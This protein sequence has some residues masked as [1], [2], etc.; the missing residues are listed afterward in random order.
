MRR[1]R[2]PWGLYAYA[3]AVY[4]F[5]FAPI[6]VVVVNSFNSDR[7][8]VDWGGFTLHWY[9]D[10]W[11]N[12]TIL[13]AAWTSLMIAAI[14]AGV[15]TMLGTSAALALRRSRRW[16]RAAINGTT[17]ARLIVP[18]LVLALALLIVF[19]RIEIG[20]GL[21]TIIVGHV[22]FTTAYVTV[23]V[24]ARLAMQEPFVEEAARDLGATPLRAFLRVTLPGLM[25]GIIAAGVL[26][27][28]FSLDNVVTSFFLAGSTNT[29]PV[30]ILSLIRFEVS[31]IVNA[32]GT[33]LTLVNCLCLVAFLLLNRRRAIDRPAQESREVTP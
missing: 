23:I 15:G 11:T 31:P 28:T 9:E 2:R 30:V 24:S 19:T 32:L 13:D 26:A 1:G 27:F 21:V 7:F 8:R 20:R 33:T 29:L 14:V 22:V 16:T 3:L 25:P 5:L 4:V 12:P 6:V 18:E 10:A 17:Y